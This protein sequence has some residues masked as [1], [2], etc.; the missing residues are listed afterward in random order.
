[1]FRE[2]LAPQQALL[3][4]KGRTSPQAHLKSLE[5]EGMGPHGHQPRSGAFPQ[6]VTLELNLEK[7]STVRE[8]GTAFTESQEAGIVKPLALV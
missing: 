2:V 1:M 3:T 5:L 6:E 7:W 4:Q 8:R